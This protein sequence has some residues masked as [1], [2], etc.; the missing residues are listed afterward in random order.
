MYAAFK[1]GTEMPEVVEF[2]EQDSTKE[3][4]MKDLILE[5]TSYRPEDRPTSTYVFRHA[6]VIYTRKEPKRKVM[7]FYLF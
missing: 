1:Q 6:Y 4:E 3:K 5:M 7:K 2:T